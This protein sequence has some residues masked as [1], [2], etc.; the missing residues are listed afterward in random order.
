MNWDQ[1]EG[2]WKE[3][4]GNARQRWAR[5]TVDDVNEIRGRREKLEGKIQELYGTTRANVKDEV[6]AW[7]SAL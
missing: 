2:Q 6:E 7:R 3:L 4:K 5:L 1:I